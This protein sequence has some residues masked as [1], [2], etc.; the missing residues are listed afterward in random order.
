[1]LEQEYDAQADMIDD[2]HESSVTASPFVPGFNP[3]GSVQNTSHP[4][5]SHGINPYHPSG[6]GVSGAYGNTNAILGNYEPMLDADPFGL[7]A[8]MHFQTPFSYEQNNSRQ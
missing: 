6:E 5:T 3:A 4:M 1:M 7:S 8:S 2:E